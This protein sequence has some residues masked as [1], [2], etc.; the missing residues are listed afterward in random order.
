MYMLIAARAAVRNLLDPALDPTISKN[1]IARYREAYSDP[2]S[3]VLDTARVRGTYIF[4]PPTKIN[5]EPT[6]Y[7]THTDSI[8]HTTPAPLKVHR[9]HR[10]PRSAPQHTTQHT[11]SQI[12][13]P[14]FSHQAPKCK[15][16]RETLTQAPST[17]L[18]RI[19]F[20]H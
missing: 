12:H 7:T 3:H 5:E 4:P 8:L 16:R 19:L 1:D 20:C 14:V 13:A 9:H 15:Q 2:T 6:Y 11:T 10:A 18:A 17:L